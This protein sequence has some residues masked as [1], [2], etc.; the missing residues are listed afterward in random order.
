MTTLHVFDPL[1]KHQ[2]GHFLGQQ[3]ALWQLC[4]R[5]GYNMVSYCHQDFDQSLLPKGITVIQLFEPSADPYLINH[6]A[7][8]LSAS[9]QHCFNDLRKLDHTRFGDN[10]ILFLTSATASHVLAYGQWLSLFAG[11][12]N[13]K[14]CLYNT[15]SAE[16]DDTV[17]RDL[18]R[19]GVIL[20]DQ[21]FE[22]LDDIVI[23]N[24][25]K[26]SM[27]RF[28]FNSIPGGKADNYTVFYEEPFP[29]RTYLELCSHSQVQFTYLHSMYPG[30]ARHTA[31]STPAESD[32]AD[33]QAKKLS[34]T[35][36]YLG[37]GGVGENHKGQHLL[38]AIIDAVSA[39]NPTAQFQLQLGSAASPDAN[40]K[41]T[42]LGEQL[43]QRFSH[44]DIT[45]GM[46]SCAD[47]CQRLEAADIVILPYGPR[48][49]HIMSGI[50]DDCLWL[51]IPC[52][53]PAR[54]KMA[55]WLERHNIQ[56]P[57]FRDWNAEAIAA[58]VTDAI[59][60]YA[61]YRQQFARAQTLC[62]DRWQLNNPFAAIGIAPLDNQPW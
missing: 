27:Y 3:L 38:E 16:L 9:N 60:H 40:D 14:V 37:S 7:T 46:T 18:K 28:L 32:R 53:I 12:F 42:M 50:F 56:F 11:Q 48:Y 41:L 29:N 44:T 33:T 57:G 15:V 17:G 51:G 61:F 10:D 4:Q 8:V 58:A 59:T 25:L 39:N 62:H 13:G 23:N 35:I 26:R 24:E 54:S 6:Y 36:T 21:S 20:S 45:Y 1:L 55:M 19:N 47:Y 2:G 30:S 52:V 43:S 22:H 34:P 5:A 31:G 49:R